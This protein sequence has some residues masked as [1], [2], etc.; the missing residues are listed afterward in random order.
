MK[1]KI[2]LLCSIL[3]KLLNGELNASIAR[4]KIEALSIHDELGNIHSN[5]LHYF[6]DEDIREKDPAYK[7]LQR[8]AYSPR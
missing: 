6:D 4:K 8:M 2:G 5:L 1:S 7:G 3:E